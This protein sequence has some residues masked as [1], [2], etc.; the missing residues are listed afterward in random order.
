MAYVLASVL[1]STIIIILGADNGYSKKSRE[2]V[3]HTSI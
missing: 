1:L 2:A 3:N